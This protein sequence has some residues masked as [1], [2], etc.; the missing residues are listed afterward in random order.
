[1]TNI[2]REDVLHLARL[3]QVSLTEDEITALES[4]LTAIIDYFDQLR[5]IDT[6]GVEPTYSVNNLHNVWREDEVQDPLAPRDQLIALA[7]EKTDNEIVVPKV[8]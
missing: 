8:L 3:S 1:M 2:T 7:A 6:E 4:D 5:E